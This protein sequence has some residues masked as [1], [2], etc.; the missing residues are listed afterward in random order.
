MRILTTPPILSSAVIASIGIAS[1]AFAPAAQGQT[2]LSA[3]IGVGG[4]GSYQRQTVER[5]SNRTYTVEVRGDRRDG[6]DAVRKDALYKAAK[7]TL[8]KD[9]DWFRVINQETDT[10]VKEV[11]TRN[12]NRASAG[13]EREPVRSCGLLGCKTEYRTTYSARSDPFERDRFERDREE[14]RYTV[15]LDY[16]MGTGPVQDIE[17]VYD[18]RRVKNDRS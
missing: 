8:K 4:N 18:A 11:S 6:R 2:S 7:E 13:F 9:Y 5:T 16:I 14:T 17:A 1:L 12:S 15:R 10:E 3:N